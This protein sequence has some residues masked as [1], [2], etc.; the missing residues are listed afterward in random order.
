MGKEMEET[1]QRFAMFGSPNMYSY[2]GELDQCA[3]LAGSV[4]W[5]DWIMQCAVCCVQ[6]AVCVYLL[7]FCQLSSYDVQSTLI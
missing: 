2:L 5:V 1:P 6:C 4:C 3:V 7:Q